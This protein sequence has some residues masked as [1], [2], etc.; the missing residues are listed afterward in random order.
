[1]SDERVDVTLREAHPEGIG[2][3]PGLIG[4]VPRLWKYLRSH[5]P[6]VTNRAGAYADAIVDK[7]RGEGE[8]LHAVAEGHRA[9]AR[10]DDANADLISA[11]AEAIRAQTAILLAPLAAENARLIAE[12]D[13]AVSPD[14]LVTAAKEQLRQAL[15]A[16][17]A[18]GVTL[19]L[20]PIHQEQRALPGPTADAAGGATPEGEPQ[21]EG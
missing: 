7:E 18:M 16:A 1:M 11:R 20:E 10:V 4:I 12:R 8:V 19:S 13:A 3:I 15:A 5:F 6:L 14:K 21:L 9:R 17:E 2:I